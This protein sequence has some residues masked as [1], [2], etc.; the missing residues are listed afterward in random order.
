MDNHQGSPND[1]RR[2]LR[3]VEKK[4]WRRRQAVGKMKGKIGIAGLPR[5]DGCLNSQRSTDVPVVSWALNVGRSTLN[6]SKH[7]GSSCP[8]EYAQRTAA[9]GIQCEHLC[10]SIML[11]NLRRK[12]RLAHCP[13]LLPLKCS[14]AIPT[15]MRSPVSDEF[16]L[17]SAA[18]S[19]ARS[20]AKALISPRSFGRGC[21]ALSTAP[22]RLTS[23][24]C[25]MYSIGHK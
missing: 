25:R 24:D 4:T 17:F 6:A 16:A 10:C 11:A 18:R 19:G 2:N 21:A 5:G 8:L 13:R 22:A 23:V 7:Y 3:G 15:L 12:R 9:V 1:I 20:R 14:S